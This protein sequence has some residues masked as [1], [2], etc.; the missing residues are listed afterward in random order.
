[1]A[2]TVLTGH[3][4]EPPPEAATLNTMRFHVPI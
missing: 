1:M 2:P 4:L 3:R